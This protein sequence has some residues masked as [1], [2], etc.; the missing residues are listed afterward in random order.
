MAVLLLTILSVYFFVDARAFE[1]DAAAVQDFIIEF[2]QAAEAMNRGFTREEAAAYLERFTVEAREPY[3]H[4]DTQ[5]MQDQTR[6]A[7]NSLYTM[8]PA[9]RA[10]DATFTLLEIS[11]IQ[12]IAT[13]AVRVVFVVDIDIAG[14]DEMDFYFNGLGQSVAGRGHI[15]GRDP[16]TITATL[17]RPGFGGQWRFAS[18]HMR[19]GTMLFG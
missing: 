18:A 2:V 8:P 16:Y 13:H 3:W 10:T 17:F 19:R 14:A 15:F 11:S 4:P 1:S 5:S 9:S 6:W 12:K 7:L